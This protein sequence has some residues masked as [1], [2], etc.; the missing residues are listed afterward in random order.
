MKKLK[1]SAGNEGAS[2]GSRLFKADPDGTVMVPDD[3]V[4]S[5]V[6]VGGFEV[7]PLPDGHV[8]MHSLVGAQI[9]ST[10]GQIFETDGDN[11]IVVPMSLADELI[12]HNFEYVSVEEQEAETAPIATVVDEPAPVAAEDDDTVILPALS[13]NPPAVEPV[14][15]AEPVAETVNEPLAKAEEPV[16]AETVVEPAA[17]T[18]TVE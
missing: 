4:P 13:L 17:E 12:S 5:L 6:G 10:S 16:A 7:M 8:K 11:M 15:A 1:G 14:V 2:F 9:V 3:A 18:K